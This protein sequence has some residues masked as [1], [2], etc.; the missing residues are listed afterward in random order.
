MR[1]SPNSL[2]RT[3]HPRTHLH[4]HSRRTISK[5]TPHNE[6]PSTPR[7]TE[8]LRECVTPSGKTESR[9]GEML[10]WAFPVHGCQ[11]FHAVSTFGK[12][13]PV[14]GSGDGTG[15]PNTEFGHGYRHGQVRFA[16]HGEILAPCPRRRWTVRCIRSILFVV[17]GAS[18]CVCGWVGGEGKPRSKSVGC[19]ARR[20]G[21]AV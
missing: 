12:L 21:V 9:Q 16:G 3:K 6:P 13:W 15:G 18:L 7:H 20:D 14:A 5:S 19:H 4:L 8:V 17:V 11:E 1:D 2:C 10:L